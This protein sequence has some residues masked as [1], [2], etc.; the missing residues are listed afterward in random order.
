MKGL[1]A[2][3]AMTRFELKRGSEH[4]QLDPLVLLVDALQVLTVALGKGAV[5]DKASVLLLVSVR[6]AV[7]LLPVNVD[8]ECIISL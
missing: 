2:R 6:L 7:A 4:A 3:F 5:L 8:Q 1:H